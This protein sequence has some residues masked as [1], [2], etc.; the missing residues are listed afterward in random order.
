MDMK[1]LYEGL[2]RIQDKG[3]I[4][5]AYNGYGDI[6][7]DD[8]YVLEY[9]YDEI[10]ERYEDDFPSWA[11]AFIQVYSWQ[12]QSLHESEETYYE[13]HYGNSEPEA[14]CR[15]ANY[16]HKNGYHE[17][18]RLYVSPIKVYLPDITGIAED[19]FI[20]DQKS[21]PEVRSDEHMEMEIVWHFYVDILEAHQAELV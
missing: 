18:Q 1:K 6:M 15:T 13:N 9:F 12:F 16:L 20:D 11:E 4:A 8:N 7:D 3:E 21:L 5:N 19:V 14:I 17:L 10:L 2:K